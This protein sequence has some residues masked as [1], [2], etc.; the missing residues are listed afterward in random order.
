MKKSFLQFF[1]YTFLTLIF[2]TSCTSFG[3]P[4]R[5]LF[6]NND[7]LGENSA[8]DS[9]KESVTNGEDD[10][11]E[12]EHS[13]KFMKDKVYYTQASI[14]SKAKLSE[15]I[16]DDYEYKCGFSTEFDYKL[17]LPFENTKNCT[18]RPSATVV[19]SGLNAEKELLH[20]LNNSYKLNNNITLEN[21]CVIVDFNK[22]LLTEIFD[23]VELINKLSE[24]R[25]YLVTFKLYDENEKKY[26]DSITIQIRIGVN[27]A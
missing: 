27:I 7:N 25:S 16:T 6:A 2:F 24:S 22:T 9:G 1:C 15:E 3:A 11:E 14:N 5:G 18:V 17:F 20:N 12:I 19:Y 26:V 13:V 23:N 10:P 8:D 21:N 4:V